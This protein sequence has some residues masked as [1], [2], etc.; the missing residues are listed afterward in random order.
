MNE[1][2]S[3]DYPVKEHM[4]FQRRMWVIERAGWAVLVLIAALGLAGLFGSG[5]LSQ[6]KIEGGSLSVAYERFERASRLSEFS[7]RFAPGQSER[8]LHLNGDFQRSYEI[9]RIQPEP[10]RS[11]ASGEGLSLTFAVPSS[12][13]TVV[14]RAHARS[15][16]IS[17]IEVGA[18]NAPP[19]AFSVMIYP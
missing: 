12:G 1:F 4:R 14:L 17:R 18:D 6:G 8:T 16:G 13:G 19:L 15:Y 11:E 10:V 2:A 5:F 3:R 7:F 9:T